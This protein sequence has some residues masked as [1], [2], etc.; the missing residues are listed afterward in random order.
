[1]EH[2]TIC[3][4]CVAPKEKKQVTLRSHAPGYEMPVTLINGAK[5]GKTVLITAAIHGDEYPGIAASIQVAKEIVPAD[6]TGR[7]LIFPCVNTGG[8]RERARDV[9]EDGANLNANYPGNPAGTVGERIADFF[10]REVFPQTDF[11]IDL[12]SG[13][14]MEPLTP[15][16][17]F[18]AAAGARVRNEAEEAARATDIPY[19]IASAASTGE[20]S[21]A[22]SA[23]GIPGLLLER[24]HGGLCKDTWVKAYDKD[25]RLLLRHLDVYPFNDGGNIC[26]KKVY[27]KT[28]YLSAEQNGLWYPYISADRHV[29]KGDALGRM[30]DFW[31]NIIAEYRAEAEGTVFYY[32]GSLAVKQNQPLVAYGLEEYVE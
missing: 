16:L 28:V 11:V 22:A 1:M 26:S 19:L 4:Y 7:I 9:P 12:H 25:I 31:G 17:F 23:M 30:E 29:L 27:R 18:P 15:C 5:P 24:G 13:G 2:W 32:T 10:V 6:V 8:F 14:A 3:G 21:Y 20:Y